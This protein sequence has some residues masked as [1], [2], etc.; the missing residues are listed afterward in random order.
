MA[1]E[2]SCWD[3]AAMQH[4]PRL[5]LRDEG[6]VVAARKFA[7]ELIGT[8]T[9]DFAA[10]RRANNEDSEE[11]MQTL[12]ASEADR[13]SRAIDAESASQSTAPNIGKAARLRQVPTIWAA[14][15]L[16]IWMP[17]A[18]KFEKPDRA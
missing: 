3:P 2:A 1:Q 5:L 12:I 11:V 14:S 15:S 17:I 7:P 18:E 16:S 8:C 9:P 6:V 4:M 10:I 13:V